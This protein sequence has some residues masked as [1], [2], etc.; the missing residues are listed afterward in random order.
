MR[1]SFPC[2]ALSGNRPEESAEP[3]LRWAVPAGRRSPYGS[4]WLAEMERMEGVWATWSRVGLDRV[5]DFRYVLT[6]FN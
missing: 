3:S 4:V 5:S 6:F 2:S 1:T